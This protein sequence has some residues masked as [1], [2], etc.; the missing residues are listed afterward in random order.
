MNRW[1]S[2]LLI[3]LFSGAAFFGVAQ[4]QGEESSSHMRNQI[5]LS[6]YRLIDP[7]NPG[8][9]I[10]Y[11]R[12]HGQR[13][14][15]QI[16]LGYMTDNHIRGFTPYD[17]YEGVRIGLEEKFY[18]TPESRAKSY[19]SLDLAYLNVRIR[20]TESFTH[21]HMY[22]IDDSSYYYYDY[23]TYTDQFTVHKQTFAV[24]VKY[25]VQ[26]PVWK[27]VMDFSVGVG[28]KIKKIRHSD[29]ENSLDDL[30]E[31]DRHMLWG[32]ATEAGTFR[33]LNFPLNVRVGYWF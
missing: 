7:V 23:Y 16:A 24:N 17:S 15:T 9:E 5:K 13:L 33:M 18:L 12:R 29:R 19:F 20:D 6:P 31:E 4:Q 25:G 8:L 11:E 10:S 26:V 32:S 3:T 30:Y 2:S 27:F 14:S 22:T 1:L 21:P 28:F